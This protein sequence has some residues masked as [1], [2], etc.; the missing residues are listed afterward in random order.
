M[1]KR[2]KIIQKR[3]KYI[4]Y[5]AEVNFSPCVYILGVVLSTVTMAIESACLSASYFKPVQRR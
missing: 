3:E 1:I 4:N 2:G 5:R